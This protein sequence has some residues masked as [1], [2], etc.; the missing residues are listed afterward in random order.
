[1]PQLSK[2][3]LIIIAIVVVV[4]IIIIIADVFLFLQYRQSQEEAQRQAKINADIQQVQETI[5]SGQ[6]AQ[7]DVE[8]LK[9]Q[10]LADEAVAI[11]EQAI[12]EEEARLAAEALKRE[13]EKTD[14]ERAMELISKHL[15]ATYGSLR[16]DLVDQTKKDILDN[17]D[18]IIPEL[19]KKTKVQ[20]INTRYNAYQVLYI[21][22]SESEPDKETVVSILKSGLTDPD[23]V[24]KAR[25]G[26][27]LLELGEKQGI[28]ALLEISGEEYGNMIVPVEPAL[29]VDE[30]A[31]A[32]LLNAI[33][34][35]EEVRNLGIVKWWD[36]YQDQIQWDPQIKKYRL[37]K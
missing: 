4:V 21:I 9:Q 14:E 8:E 36:K 25:A 3:T 19:E 27:W 24:N 16:Q 31:S 5:Q 28:P 20:D 34:L 15:V 2:K 35:D 12:K 6:I 29:S 17:K 33:L 30:F 32:V 11:A 10:G 1:M 23:P 22:G 26:G 7:L 13:E 37:V 18:L